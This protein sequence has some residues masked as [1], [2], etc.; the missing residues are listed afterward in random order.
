MSLPEKEAPMNRSTAP[1]KVRVDPHPAIG[2][3]DGNN[4]RHASPRKRTRAGFFMSGV[5]AAMGLPDD[6]RHSSVW[7]GLP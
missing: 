6:W 7:K 2:T 3:M 5:R 4:T 1:A